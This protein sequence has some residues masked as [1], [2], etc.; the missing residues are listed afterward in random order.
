MAKRLE[1]GFTGR[2]VKTLQRQLIR[3]NDNALQMY[4]VDGSYGPETEQAVL[5]FQQ[6]HSDIDNSGIADL[7]TQARLISVISYDLGSTGRGVKLLQEALMRFT[8]DLPSGADGSYGPETKQGVQTF[9][10]HNVILD[11]GIAGAVTFDTLDKALN[12]YYLEPGSS[13]T[14]YGSVTRMVQS[15]LNEMGFSLAVDGSYGPA[16]EQAIRTFQEREGLTEDGVAGPRTMNL[17]DIEAPHPYTQSEMSQQLEEAGITSSEVSIDIRSKFITLLE[18]DPVFINSFPSV[19]NP[20]IA[21][22]PG[23][24]RVTGQSSTLKN[25][26]LVSG[27]LIN[28]ENLNFYSFIDEDTEEIVTQNVFDISGAQYNDQVK[29]YAYDAMNDKI[30]DLDVKWVDLDDALLQASLQYKETGSTFNAVQSLSIGDDISKWV[31]CEGFGYSSCGILTLGLGPGAGIAC[32]AAW[33]FTTVVINPDTC[34][35]IYNTFV[36]E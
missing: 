9:Q 33:A 26:I 32:S 13:G 20:E 12:T 18:N 14:I 34:Q 17:L 27:K 10:Q 36:P 30:T 29:L 7:T 6:K 19:S 5:T 1:P 28:H 3:E 11:N 22:T 8:I 23:V 31:V 35:Q 21:S 4:G 24:L 2:D 16:T 25:I 15:Q